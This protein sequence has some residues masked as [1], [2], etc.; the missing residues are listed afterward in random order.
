MSLHIMDDFPYQVL[1]GDKAADSC[2]LLDNPVFSP[3]TR[4]L[5][6]EKPIVRTSGREARGDISKEISGFKI[7][8]DAGSLLTN[9]PR[10]IQ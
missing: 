5:F 9:A 7:D 3:L 4:L 8:T 6:A 1:G 10:G 2:K